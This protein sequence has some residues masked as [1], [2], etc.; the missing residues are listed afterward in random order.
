MY[1]IMRPCVHI[2]KLKQ[3]KTSIMFIKVF[4]IVY[5]IILNSS[6]FRSNSTPT[7][8]KTKARKRKNWMVV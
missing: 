1:Y 6:K 3:K 4:N 2:F 8:M 7:F 5:F